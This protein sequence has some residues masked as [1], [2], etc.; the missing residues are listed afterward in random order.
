MSLPCSEKDSPGISK[1]HSPKSHR[2]KSFKEKSESERPLDEINNH[3][4]S[5]ISHVAPKYYVREKGVKIKPL[6]S[7]KKSEERQESRQ[8]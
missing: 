1:F 6:I 3:G 4:S 8:S 2:I 5:R 7:S